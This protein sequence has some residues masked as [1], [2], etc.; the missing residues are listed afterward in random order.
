[1]VLKMVVISPYAEHAKIDYLLAEH[2][3]KLVTR[4]L[5]MRKNWLIVGGAVHARKLAGYSLAVSRKSFPR[6][7][8]IFRVFLVLHL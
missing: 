1:M 7:T 6:S 2:L 8:C 4:W 3:Q 5:S